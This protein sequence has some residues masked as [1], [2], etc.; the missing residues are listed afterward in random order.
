MENLYAKFAKFSYKLFH[1]DDIV[2]VIVRVSQK[3]H[4]LKI[5]QKRVPLPKHSGIYSIG[6]MY[7]DEY[8]GRFNLLVTKK[9]VAKN[10]QKHK[11]ASIFIL[12]K[13]YCSSMIA[14]QTYL[15]L[16]ESHTWEKVNEKLF[17]KHVKSTVKPRIV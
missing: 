1:D 8:P 13:I 17:S 12:A 5:L 11:N 7:M 10:S 4:F 16:I 3:P 2:I 14:N 9:S 15:N 6:R